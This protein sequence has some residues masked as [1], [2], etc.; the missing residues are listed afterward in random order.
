MTDQLSTE[1]STM[2]AQL[3]N[4]LKG[5]IPP[6]PIAASIGFNLTAVTPGL[7]IVALEA[8]SQHAHPMGTLHGGVLCDR[9]CQP[10]AGRIVPH[11]GAENQ[12]PPACLEAML[13]GEGKVLKQGRTTGPVECRITDENGCLV[14]HATSTCLTLRGT[15]AHGR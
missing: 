15:A 13:K 3:K 2:F 11:P 6:P 14:A 10:G 12:L 9:A 7:A 5:K 1:T 4:R 8:G